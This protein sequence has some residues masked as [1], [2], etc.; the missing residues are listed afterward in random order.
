MCFA[1]FGDEPWLVVLSTGTSIDT[2]ALNTVPG[3][4]LVWSQVPQLEVL[5]HTS[6][7]ITQCGMNSVMESL[8][9]A[10]PMVGVP[11]IPEQMITARCI[12]E[13]QLGTVLDTNTLT[14]E[15]LRTAVEQ[16]MANP[17]YGANAK[18]MQQQVHNAGGYTRAADAIMHFEQNHRQTTSSKA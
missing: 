14:V 18:S 1:A 10:V 16:A 3:N 4:F 2:A 5:Q 13:F 8:Y 6:L 9:Y 12:Q 15:K 17:T 7:F 11:Q